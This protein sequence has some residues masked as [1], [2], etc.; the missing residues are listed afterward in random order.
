MKGEENFQVE[1]LFPVPGPECTPVCPSGSVRAV[2]SRLHAGAGTWAGQGQ[3]CGSTRGPR[4]RGRSCHLP[5]RLPRRPGTPVGWLSLRFF[6]SRVL[7][8]WGVGRSG[9][10][11]AMSLGFHSPPGMLGLGEPISL[12]SWLQA[13]LQQPAPPKFTTPSSPGEQDVHPHRLSPGTGVPS[14]ARQH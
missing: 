12:T 5:H 13:Q 6:Q 9:A 8:G 11:R 1:L 7:G 4:I 10:G 14:T 3:R 2:T